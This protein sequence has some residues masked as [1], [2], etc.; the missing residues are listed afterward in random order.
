M[1]LL[2]QAALDEATV[3]STQGQAV[4]QSRRDLSKLLK[5]LVEAQ[6]AIDKWQQE[7]NKTCGACWIAQT[8][9]SPSIALVREILD[10]LDEM[11]PL[12]SERD[13]LEDRVK[14]MELNET[15]FTNDV[16]EFAHEMK[17]SIDGQ[18]VLVLTDRLSARI[19]AASEKSLLQK[20]KLNDLQ[21][22]RTKVKDC[23][24]TITINLTEMQQV[25][26]YLGVETLAAAAAKLDEANTKANL[27]ARKAEE[28]SHITKALDVGSMEEA[29]IILKTLD[30]A[31]LSTQK[32]AAKNQFTD[33]DERQRQ[34]HT[35][36]C[37]AE[38]LIE[39]IGGDASVA[40]I[41]EQR[42][43][44]CLEIQ[45]KARQWM[46]LRAGIVAAERALRVY[47]EK[48]C[49]S[50]LSNASEA[51]ATISRGAYSKLTT[52]PEGTGETLVGLVATGGSRTAEE[53]S[54]G[55]RFQ[56]YLA[57]RVAGYQE[58]ANSREP[59]MGVPFIAD[60]IM[61]TYDDFRAEEAFRVLSQMAE[62]GQVIYLTHHEHLCGIARKI[63][64]DVRIHGFEP[65]MG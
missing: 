6:K 35:A 7:W 46:R 65:S 4:D 60:D 45:D 21:K 43:T 32:A 63:C 24:E 55:T 19:K 50:M 3:I 59:P 14:K 41:E 58:Y 11:R 30:A 2:S 34:Y 17:E 5:R 42:R 62:V 27:L 25:F 51:F 57:L 8:H 28:E 18:S 48:H 53:M 44:I 20:G 64:P 56:L 10:K 9:A 36:K 23:R 37:N 40:L 15:N 54:K 16:F 29:E 49:S 13:G 33:A 12:L 38:A 61:E 52:K 39:A 31:A 1:M 26:A 22:A 47:R